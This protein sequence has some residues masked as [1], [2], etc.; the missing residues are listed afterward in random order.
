MMTAEQLAPYIDHTLLNSMATHLEVENHCD[1]AVEYGFGTICVLPRWVTLAADRLAQKNVNVG[2]VVSF[3]HGADS[4]KQKIA[5]A[6]QIIFDGADEIDMVADLASIL[7][8]DAKYFTS[9]IQAMV[10]ICHS[11]KPAVTLKVIIE[12]AA[13]TTDQKLF[14]CTILEKCSVDFI[15]TSTGLNPAGGATLEDVR[16]IKQAAPGCRVK[17]AGGIR[18]AQQAWDM[19]EAGAE[20]IGTTSAI[21][22]IQELGK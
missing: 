22:I 4:T 3:P 12:S 9:Q 16:L 20:R 10:R 7:E 6:Q 21:A 11:M 8:S 19:I 15:K 5:Q 17:A 13:L 18:T 14:A 1:Q 2:S